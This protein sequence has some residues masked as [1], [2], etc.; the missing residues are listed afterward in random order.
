MAQGVQ[1]QSSG[2]G[3]TLNHGTISSAP[4]HWL[5]YVLLL[6]LFHYFFPDTN[7]FL[8]I[9]CFGVWILLVFLEP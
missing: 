1:L 3:H 8:P 5:F 9:Y 4:M 2:A 7:Y 6:S